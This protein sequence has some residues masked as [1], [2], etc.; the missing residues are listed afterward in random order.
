MVFIYKFWKQEILIQ[1]PEEPL[2]HHL[3]EGRQKKLEL[4]KIS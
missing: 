4:H 2:E 1:P 3:G